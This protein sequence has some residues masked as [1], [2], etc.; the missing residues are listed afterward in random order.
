MRKLK[1]ATQQFITK[2]TTL[3]NQIN[4]NNK[5]Q[6]KTSDNCGGNWG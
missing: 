1:Y 3:W 6:P 5:P 2:R 4:M